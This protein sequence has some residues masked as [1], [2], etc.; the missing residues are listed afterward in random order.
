MVWFRANRGAGDNRN[1]SIR[2]CDTQRLKQK[3][4][5]TNR[6]KDSKRSHYQRVAHKIPMVGR[7]RLKKVWEVFVLFYFSKDPIS[8]ISL[9]KQLKK[10]GIAR[11]GPTHKAEQL[12]YKPTAYIDAPFFWRFLSCRVLMR[13][14]TAAITLAP[15][16]WCQ[17]AHSNGMRHFQTKTTTSIKKPLFVD[18]ICVF[19]AICVTSEAAIPF[20]TPKAANEARKVWEMFDQNVNALTSIEFNR[21]TNR[22]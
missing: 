16:R 2:L 17:A 6:K 4:E 22:I 14:P 18:I 15:T 13:L 21:W 20:R 5:K 11:F 12:Y 3:T 19:A 1:S 7:Q 9:R 10:K 8:S